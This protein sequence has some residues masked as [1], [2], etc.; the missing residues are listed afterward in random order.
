LLNTA[1]QVARLSAQFAFVFFGATVLGLVYGHLVSLFFFALVGLVFLRDRLRVP[2]RDEFNELW[3]FARYSWLGSLTGLALNWMDVV[4]LGLFVADDL[5][6]IYQASWTLASFLALTSTSVG[7]TLFPELSELGADSRNGRVKQLVGDGLLFASVLLIPG[8][9]GALVVG[10]RVLELYSE[11]FA[12][13]A[14]ILVILIAARTLNAFGSQ[15]VSALNGLDF[16]DVA[17]RINS[18]F[19]GTNLVLNF[20]LVYLFGWYGAAVATLVSSGVLLV[21]AWYALQR[22]IGGINVPVRD[23]G[24]EVLSSVVMIGVVWVA[25]P[26]LPRNLFGTAG[27]VA[28]GAVVYF[29]V[30][31]STA[32]RIRGK[33]RT[34]V[35]A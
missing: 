7:L 10:D 13:G 16:P 19:F 27:A 18:V 25:L 24:L 12:A 34:L 29:V 15:L 32:T 2:S 8:G 9:F 22:E 20:V 31:L 4:V 33:V 6:G 14:L 35:G 17:F 3:Q 26:V 30:L 5:I 11:E 1:E 23:I 28:V 21:S